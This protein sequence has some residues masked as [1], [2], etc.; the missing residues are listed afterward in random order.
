M[1]IT[2][3]ELL[4]SREC[5]FA[6]TGCA[7]PNPL[8]TSKT[9]ISHQGT[10]KQWRRGIEQMKRLGSQFVAIY[11]AEPLTRMER[12]PEIVDH[13]HRTGMACTVITA[14][15]RSAQM[16]ELLSSSS[17][18]SVTCSYDGA[19]LDGSRKSKG[20]Q[21]QLFFNSP[22]YQHL[23]D[24]AVV[25]TVS[26]ENEHLIIDMAEQ[27]T[28]DDIWFLFDLYHPGTGPLSKCGNDDKKD[29]A[30]SKEGVLGICEALLKLKKQGRKIHASADY[31]NFLKM[32]YQGDVRSVWH[33][34]GKV[35]G[36]LTVDADGSVLPC[37]DWQKPF[38]G[39]KIWDELDE[40]RLERWALDSVEDC[41]GCSWNTHRDAIQIE[42]KQ[43]KGSSYVH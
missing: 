24:R 41:P 25:A 38:E 22:E 43:I 15:P 4:W 19:Y 27:A 20:V 28:R 21:G 10:L 26:K 17:L 32:N 36:W 1:K 13:I 14:L 11:G 35:V 40:E 31:L 34:R 23:R 7:M 37:D 2:K 5:P 6:C 16:R 30:P 12:L 39:G 3:V 33:C 29:H 9:S 18:D 8:R 42:A